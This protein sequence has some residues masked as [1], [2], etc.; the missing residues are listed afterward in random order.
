[1]FWQ[2]GHPDFPSGAGKPS[3]A[4]SNVA[5]L[6]DSSSSAGVITAYAGTELVARTAA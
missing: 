6:N 3:K 5:A 1:V 2:P 4:L